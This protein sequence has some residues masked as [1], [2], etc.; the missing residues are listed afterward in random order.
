MTDAVPNPQANYIE[1]LAQRLNK[2]DWTDSH[3]EPIGGLNPGELGFV[4]EFILQMAASG[5]APTRCALK[6]APG[7]RKHVV[8]NA[9]LL[10]LIAADAERCGRK[11]FYLAPDGNGEAGAKFEYHAMYLMNLGVQ[12]Q[13]GTWDE[14]QPRYANSYQTADLSQFWIIGD[15]DTEQPLKAGEIRDIKIQ[16]LKRVL[17]DSTCPALLLHQE[18]KSPLVDFP[19]TFNNKPVGKGACFIATAA[20]GSPLAKEVEL[21]RGFRDTVLAPRAMGRALVAIYERCS[22]PLAEWIARRPRVR[23]VVRGLLIRPLAYALGCKRPLR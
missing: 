22:P 11:I 19:P 3:G 6:L 17:R 18:N 1:G 2:A 16:G 14:I 7:V 23:K 20:C 9:G 4:T 5:S 21:L 10:P 13:F 15:L 12:V 8:L